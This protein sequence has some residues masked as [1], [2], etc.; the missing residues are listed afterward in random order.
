MRHLST[1]P[2][3]NA[4]VTE[5]RHETRAQLGL[6]SLFL[7]CAN[8]ASSD[9]LSDYR[10]CISANRL[11][12]RACR[13]IYPVNIA[14]NSKRS[15]DQK[16]L[17]RDDHQSKILMDDRRFEHVWPCGLRF[18]QVDVRYETRNRDRCWAP[19][20]NRLW[21]LPT[22]GSRCSTAFRYAFRNMNSAFR[23]A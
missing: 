5:R 16:A 22:K 15:F 7:L 20:R 8:S 11:F 2:L 1:S 23:V 10:G 19:A 4:R 12:T 18:N 9:V 21:Q 13:L 14:E 3:G 6:L 17:E